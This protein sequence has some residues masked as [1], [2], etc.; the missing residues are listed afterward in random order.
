MNRETREN[1]VT[2]EVREEPI[3]TADVAEALE[4]K[5]NPRDRELDREHPAKN[6]PLMA[7]DRMQDLRAR[8]DTIQTSF[9]D[10]PRE[11]VKKADS[12]VAELMQDLAKT[13]ATER[14]NLEGQ[15]GR[16]DNVSTED[17][18]IALQRYR[19]FFSRL[20]SV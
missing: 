14:Q 7:E 19:S 5:P 3:T 18:R 16:G 8:W 4:T 2:E 11:A 15:W 10:E 1:I 6:T 20:L 9:V 17:L 13:F 12:L